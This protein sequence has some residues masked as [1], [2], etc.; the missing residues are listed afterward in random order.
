MSTTAPMDLLREN[1]ALPTRSDPA[2]VGSAGNIGRT[3]PQHQLGRRQ[4]PEFLH[5]TPWPL[6]RRVAHASP[7][8]SGPRPVQKCVALC[9]LTGL[10]ALTLSAQQPAGTAEAPDSIAPY[11]PTPQKV[12]DEMLAASGLKPG[13]T[14]IDPGSGD[15]RIVITAAR[16]YKAN[17]IGIELDDELAASSA[18]RIKESGLDQVARIIHG[19]LLKQDYSSADVVTVYLWP[20]ANR[21]LA[22]LLDIQLRKGTRVIAH[23]FEMPTWKPT[24]IITIPDD[25][26]GRSHT[27]FLYIR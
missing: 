11:L 13:E 19:D 10:A 23:D 6:P 24:K 16:K 26:T 12:V 9:I 15:G 21:K 7:R 1:S 4:H 3:Q 25:G 5:S 2:A 22:Q 17:S 27:L 20:E 18:S 8:T 14:L